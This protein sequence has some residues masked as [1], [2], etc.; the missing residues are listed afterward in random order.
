MRTA[1]QRSIYIHWA[2]IKV[3]SVLKRKERAPSLS[4]FAVAGPPSDKKR[5][6]TYEEKKF[7]KL[8]VV[9]I[10]AS[11]GIGS[12][13]TQ[14]IEGQRTKFAQEPSMLNSKKR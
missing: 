13:C 4:I 3:S 8:E 1:V 7:E 5:K 9:S 2:D 6:V 11:S 14:G 10:T 12:E